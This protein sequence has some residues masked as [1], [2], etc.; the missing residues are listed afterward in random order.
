MDQVSYTCSCMGANKSVKSVAVFKFGHPGWLIRQKII[1]K[2]STFILNARRRCRIKRPNRTSVF[3]FGSVCWWWF[4]KTCYRAS[5]A[6][7]SLQCSRVS[8]YDS[9]APGG[10]PT[11]LEW[12]ALRLQSESFRLEGDHSELY[13]SRLSLYSTRLGSKSPDEPLQFLRWSSI[14]PGWVFGALWVQS[15]TSLL[16]IEPT[17]L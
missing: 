13:Y 14:A 1:L 11:Y 2:Y 15:D 5:H 16:Q 7:V 4:V 12:W 17:Q 9:A 3:I 6:R 10:K 8:L